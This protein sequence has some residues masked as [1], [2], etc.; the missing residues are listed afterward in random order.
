LVG[1]TSYWLR[2]GVENYVAR[3][4]ARVAR[5]LAER[6]K[7]GTVGFDWK[8]SVYISIANLA[9]ALAVDYKTARSLT[10]QL[11][12]PKPVARF[13]EANLWLRDDIEV[14]LDGGPV[15]ERSERPHQGW[16]VDRAAL[17]D[18]LGYWC[19]RFGLPAARKSLPP[20]LARAFPAPRRP[21]RALLSRTADTEG[22]PVLRQ[23][24]SC[25]TDS[26]SSNPAVSSPMSRPPAPVNSDSTVGCFTRLPTATG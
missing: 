9:R 13:G 24:G 26:T 25:S 18:Y 17:A 1:G 10:R 4:E 16:L 5:R 12:F 20:P 6:R 19:G 14:Y 21:P 7:P 11:D 23:S 22:R 15:P 8:T 3:N 2:D